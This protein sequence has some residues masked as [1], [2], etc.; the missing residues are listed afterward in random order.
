MVDGADAVMTLSVGFPSPPADIEPDRDANNVHSASMYVK[1]AR[2]HA[3]W[4]GRV[5]L[6]RYVKRARQH[7][8]WGGR[9]L[10]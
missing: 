10:A 3:W 4:G 8:W 7:A 1:R 6:E 2:Q 5:W 9:V